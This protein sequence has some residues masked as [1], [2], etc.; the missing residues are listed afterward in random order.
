MQI[1][2]ENLP[3]LWSTW[4]DQGDKISVGL[5][6]HVPMDKTRDR[7]ILTDF[8]NFNLNNTDTDFGSELT[9][10]YWVSF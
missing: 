10:Q 7:S 8:D 6:T 2:G 9:Y 3:K 1:I 5:E 4:P